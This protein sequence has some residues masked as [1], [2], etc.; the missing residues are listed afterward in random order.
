MK[1]SWQALND[2]LI[3]SPRYFD[4][5]SHTHSQFLTV[6]RLARRFLR[7]RVLDAGAGRLTYRT[8][9]EPLARRY[10]S[11]DIRAERPDLDVVCDLVQAPFRAGV[12]DAILCSQVLEHSPTPTRVLRALRE[13]LSEDGVLIL[14]VPH[15][16]YLHGEP[17]DYFRFTKYGIRV[18]LDR[19]GLEPVLIEESG[20]LLAF[21]A[22]LVSDVALTGFSRIPGVLPIAFVANRLF[23]RLVCAIERGLGEVLPLISLFPLNYAAV[24]RK[25]P[26]FVDDEN[27]SD[28]P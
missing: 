4:L 25:R 3:G 20:G 9:L 13:C 8:V 10:V 24:A 7:G 11:A 1:G 18:L 27:S 19:A 26:G 6:R 23:V 16:S 22:S 28:L 21:L 2:R 5:D 15:I 12:F 17:D 14:T